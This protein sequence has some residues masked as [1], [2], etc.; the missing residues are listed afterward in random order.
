MPFRLHQR[1]VG[2]AHRARLIHTPIPPYELF[3]ET[4]AYC[5]LKCPTC[6]QASDLGGR[7]KGNMDFELF[8]KVIDEASVWASQV[9]LF[10]SGEPLFY[11]RQQEAVE[12][13]HAKGLY[14]RVH[15]NLLLLS[16]KNIDALLTPA[17]D[18]LSVSFEGPTRNHYDKIRVKGN[19]DLA[20]ENTR[21][22]LQERARRGLRRPKVIIQSLQLQGESPETLRAGNEKLLQGLSYDE[23]K[24]VPTHNFAGYFKE[25]LRGQLAEELYYDACAML[26]NRIT[27]TWDG[28]VVACC[29][30]LNA[31]YICGDIHERP[32]IEIW[33]DKPFRELRAMLRDRRHTEV[34]LCRDCDAPY[35]AK[36]P[37][38]RKLAA[39]LMRAF[40]KALEKAG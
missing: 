34:A 28:R 26:Y 8:K 16:E 20:V 9:S 29:N 11:K 13:A 23:M 39:S 25:G 12:Y 36:K 37:P 14:T 27:V 38:E 7:V 5:N 31:K 4:T 18:E 40:A 3:I 24:I 32:L 35:C 33:N 21:W 22:L 6:P 17:L 30:D 15:T 10:L 19:F 2:L 1:L